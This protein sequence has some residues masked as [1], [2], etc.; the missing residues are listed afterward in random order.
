MLGTLALVCVFGTSGPESNLKA[1][2]QSSQS[3]TLPSTTPTISVTTSKKV[4]KISTFLCALQPEIRWKR[5]NEWNPKTCHEVA[6]AHVRESLRTGIHDL[7]GVAISIQESDLVDIALRTEVDAQG[8]PSG[9]FDG[10]LMGIRYPS[11]F[12]RGVKLVDVL[13]IKTNIR[14]GFDIL[15]H[16]KTAKLYKTVMAKVR[17][18][19]RRL[20]SATKVVEQ[21][22]DHEFFAHYQNGVAVATEGWRSRYDDRV[23]SIYTALCDRFSEVPRELKI[24]S[25]YETRD[26]RTVGLVEAIVGLSWNAAPGPKLVAEK[27][28]P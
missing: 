5:G 27:L 6:S 10:G 7:L 13:K 18:G 16:Y 23:G 26:K 20:F 9:K 14:L 22:D 11:Q 3:S 15:S 17:V 19:G 24:R 25:R 12:T 8:Q 28:A 4:E 21:H 1:T 2:L